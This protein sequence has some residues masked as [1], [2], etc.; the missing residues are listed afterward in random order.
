LIGGA[1]TGNVS[2]S[3]ATG[4]VHGAAGTGG[5]VGTITTGTISNSY[6]TGGVLGGAETGGLVGS[7]TGPIT[8]SYA[9]GMVT[10]TV[11][12]VVGAVGAASVGGLVGATTGPVS[13]SYASGAVSGGAGVGGLIGSSTGLTLN[14]YATGNVTAASNAGGLI[15]DTTGSVQNSYAAGVVSAPGAPRTTG[16]L[17]G[18]STV[19]DSNNFFD[20]QSNPGMAGVG[21]QSIIGGVTPMSAANMMVQTNFTSSTAANGNTSPAWDFASTWTILPGAMPFLQYFMKPIVV[22][23]NSSTITYN[24]LAYAGGITYSVTPTS[25]LGGT[26]S[27]SY[28]NNGVTS[29]TGPSNLGSYVVTPGGLLSNQQYLVSFASGNLVINP[30]PLTI[31]ANNV[32]KVYGTTAT[33][34]TTAFTATG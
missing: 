18:T 11:E 24:G 10:G 2:N 3:Y 30:A 34:G 22:T 32:T 28:L 6:A 8:I 19:A 9:T 26:L 25:A 20:S 4:S 12:G 29:T 27:Y 13:V 5:L 15:G 21:A 23:A 17:L 14:T 33:L 16:A 31:T 1:T 7:S